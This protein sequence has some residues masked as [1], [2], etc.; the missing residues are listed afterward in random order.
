MGSGA[1]VG[2]QEEP[3][4]L[5]WASV[6]CPGL[7]LSIGAAVAPRDRCLAGF[8]WHA[9]LADVTFRGPML[10]LSVV[11]LVLVMSQSTGAMPERR[12][13]CTVRV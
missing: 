4:A 2:V 13:G 3:V 5:R 1:G 6:G 11:R 10:A 8:M 9:L 7:Q 12:N